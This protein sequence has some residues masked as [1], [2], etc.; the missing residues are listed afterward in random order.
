VSL[1]SL[2]TLLTAAAVS[3]GS[4]QASTAAADLHAPDQGTLE[5]RV[6]TLKP[7]TRDRFHETVEREAMPLL[8]RAGI[9]VVAYGPSVHDDDSYFL[10]R[11]FRDIAERA[12][13]ED[14]FYGSAEWLRGPRESILSA[15][16]HY[17]TMVV[18]VSPETIRSFH[19]SLAG[20]ERGSALAIAAQG[21][22]DIAA[23]LALN[24][25][26]VRA[27][28]TSDV[29]RFKEILA[30][31]FVASLS[32]GTHVKR[33]A[34]LAA[35]KSPTAVT[36]LQAH[37]VDVRLMGDFAIIHARTTFTTTDGRAGASRYT[38]VWARRGGRWL[39]VSAQV[40]RYEP[41]KV[42]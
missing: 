3:A 41:A 22:S 24:D 38:D 11:A 32:D 10:V 39:C 26:Y 34:F 16:D 33:A 15:I 35:V 17:S 5:I 1:A 29:E 23:L 27:S 40:T 13:A 9:E 6:Y 12:R 21:A 14:A 20:S 18:Q 2:C 19:D 25:A 4:G 8:R 30:D 37:D 31:D 7:G 36:G 42:R 28:Q